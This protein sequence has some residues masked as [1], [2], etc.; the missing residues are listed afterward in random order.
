[1]TPTP[2]DALARELEEARI[3]SVAERVGPGLYPLLARWIL[4][5]YV[6]KGELLDGAQE[7]IAD[8]TAERDELRRRIRVLSGVEP[9]DEAKLAQSIDYANTLME[10]RLRLVRDDADYLA[11][12]RAMRTNPESLGQL[13]RHVDRCIAGLVDRIVP[14]EQHYADLASALALVQRHVEML[15]GLVESEA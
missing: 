7:L 3:I 11:R 13:E 14:L 2:V 6:R 12:E 4:H 15:R 5:R 9:S 1:V 8:L 10:R